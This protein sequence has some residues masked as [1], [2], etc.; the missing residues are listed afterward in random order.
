MSRSGSGDAAA[1][2]TKVT[3]AT[4]V[5]G[6]YV[7]VRGLGDRYSNTQLNGIELPT[8]D[9]DKKSFQLDLFPSYL[10]ENII[11]HKTFTPD[12]PGNFSG[13]LV[14][15]TTRGIPDAFFFTI[16]AKQG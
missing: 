15:V 9:P 13:G 2:M 3:G 16:S 5:G 11:T 6:K 8:S 10:L 7:F 4:V 14:D 1:A 12:K